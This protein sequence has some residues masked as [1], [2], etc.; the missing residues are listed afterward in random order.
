VATRP[1]PL[2][3]V[4]AST[5]AQGLAET[6]REE[7]LRR[8]QQRDGS[9][10][11]MRKWALLVPERGVELDFEN[12][13]FQEAWYSEE[14]ADAREAIWCKAAQVGMS[15]YAWRWAARRAEQY[16]DRVIYFFPTDDDVADFGDQRIEP[17]IEDSPLL[18]RR[19]KPDYVHH[20]HLKRI[21]AG[22]L[23]LRGTRSKSAVQ[24]VDADALVFDEYDYLDPANL[25]QAER[26]LAGAVAAGR[27]PRTRRLGYP[28]LPGYGIDALYQRSDK[29]IWHVT[30]PKCEREQA[31]TWEANMRW[32]VPGSDEVMRAGHDEYA[33]RDDVDRA[34][35]AC[36]DCDTSLEPAQEGQK[37]PI[38]AGRWISTGS[39][40]VI[41]FHVSRLIVPR[42]DLLELV[43][44]SRKTAPHEVEAFY[45]N[46]LGLAYSPSEAS[47]TPADIEAAA[48]R[49]HRH[50]L[51]RYRGRFPVLM[52]LDV[53]SE[54]NL[55][56]VIDELLPSGERRELYAGEPRDFQEAATLIELFGVHVVVV[57]ALPER[58][59]ARAL[60][61]TFPGRV[62]LAAYDWRNEADAFLYNGKKNL[63]T[64]NRTEAID[65]TFDAIRQQR[66]WPLGVPPPRYVAQM[67]APKRR[68]ELDKKGKPV[69][70]YVSTGT[71]GDDY[72]HAEV[73][74]M[75]AGE[76]YGMLKMM[77][78]QQRLAAG[79]PIADERLGFRRPH[80]DLDEDIES[81]DGRGGR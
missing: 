75:V 5:S 56:C 71:E 22:W 80:L 15:A 43:R 23:G 52:G 32:T 55:N 63:V 53:A 24:S 4:R 39:G 51:S 46:D 16:A 50:A 2:L 81:S 35:R 68:T 54:R 57:D 42:T 38:H 13:P 1:R 79:Q 29:R 74:V 69:R 76:L 25:A 78:K 9:A 7:V 27:S 67:C 60:A 10:R 49:G 58:R 26:R 8:R 48:S 40:D 11:T 73:Y 31:L 20:K 18:R 47:L 77:R 34:W 70:S 62:F 66:K 33:N 44:N 36:G 72:A 6:V 45:N 21:G 61:Q 17:S 3:S 19:I 12:F 37:G 41:G 59:Q 30:C 28:T 65:A 64:I 14:V